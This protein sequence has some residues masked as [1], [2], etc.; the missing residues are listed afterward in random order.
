MVRCSG[1]KHSWAAA[2]A[3]AME[4]VAATQRNGMAI[5]IVDTSISYTL[6]LMCSIYCIIAQTI[7]KI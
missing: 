6:I 4:V 2:A 5:H 7:L 1:L 3:T